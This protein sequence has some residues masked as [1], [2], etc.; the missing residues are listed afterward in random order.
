MDRKGHRNYGSL[1]DL[2]RNS[3]DV[4]QYYDEWADDYDEALAGWRYQAPEQVAARM[5][6]MLGRDAIILDAG[7]GTGLS[8][9]A[10]AAAGFETIDG[11][12]VSRRSLEVAERL[13]V[14][15]TLRHADM[16]QL[17]LPCD[18]DIYDGLACVG[19]L[20]YIPDSAAI[21]REFARVVRP[22]GSMVLTQ[23][24]DLLD[25]RDFPATLAALE[26][27]GF[28]QAPDVSE[29]MPYLPDNEEFSDEVR[30]HYITCTVAQ[31]DGRRQ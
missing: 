27:E 15:R 12:D 17:P 22:G 3:E 11:I 29:S 8:G 5:R 28:I 18:D 16:Q 21:L 24:S 7:C 2:S 23:R 20:T 25:E 10:L 26:D 1:R 6:A 13:G 30:V 4:A 14:Y 19:V 31:P 9:R